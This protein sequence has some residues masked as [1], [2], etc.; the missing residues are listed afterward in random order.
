MWI[1]GQSHST[2]CFAFCYWALYSL[3][4]KHKVAITLF[5]N[6]D[7]QMWVTEGF[8]VGQVKEVH[9]HTSI[10][11]QLPAKI[12]APP[13]FLT[14]PLAGREKYRLNSWH[15]EKYL[16]PH[17]AAHDF[18][19]NV[20]VRGG[21]M[22][23]ECFLSMCQVLSFPLS[24]YIVTRLGQLHFPFL[25]FLWPMTYGLAVITFF[26]GKLTFK[27]TTKV[28][29]RL[30]QERKWGIQAGSC[31][32]SSTDINWAFWR[33]KKQ[34]RVESKPR[35]GKCWLEAQN[36]KLGWNEVWE[37]HRISLINHW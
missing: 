18:S 11:S 9:P 10:M 33:G 31:V 35:G 13:S 25:G 7:P 3:H 16:I 23:E 5:P 6:R 29:V 27:L 21:Y 37:T 2:A 8:R 15:L 17:Q 28:A 14:L 24:I 22:L 12:T 32:C 36:P 1:S 20:S 34:A 26:F 30:T 19:G 4:R